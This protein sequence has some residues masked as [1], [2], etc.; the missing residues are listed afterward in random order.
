VTVSLRQH[1]KQPCHAAFISSRG[2]V[3]YV[4]TD[5]SRHAGEAG[6][7]VLD[8]KAESAAKRAVA[9][10]LRDAQPVRAAALKA[11]LD[12]GAIGTDEAV[13]HILTNTLWDA[14]LEELEDACGLLGLTIPEGGWGVSRPLGVLL[15]HAGDDLGQL[16]PVVLAVALARGERTLAK[17]PSRTAG[18]HVANLH[19]WL[20][21]S[22]GIH[23]LSDAERML[24]A[25][26][27]L[28]QWS[29][30]CHLLPGGTAITEK[31]TA[32]AG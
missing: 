8:L 11:A 13:R 6:S 10:E 21:D 22:T 2:E 24:I 26:R 20:L 29:E 18:P 12:N 28:R 5:R 32:E 3:A 9:K 7:G 17:E 27:G 1:R 25:E 4:C 23:R 16:T 19:G 14:R 31:E 30:C 15:A